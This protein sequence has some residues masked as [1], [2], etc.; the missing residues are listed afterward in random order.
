MNRQLKLGIFVFSGII[1]VAVSIIASGNFSFKRSYNVYA[2]FNDISGIT[3]KA[4]VKIAGVDIGV[5]KDISLEGSQANLK[6][7]I[8]KDI[9]LY[10]NS[11]VRIVSVG[12]IGTKYIEISPGDSSTEELKEGYYINAEQ[13]SD[14]ESMFKNI[15]TS[16]N[17]GMNSHQ[18]GDLMENLA[19][20]IYSLK[21]VMENLGHENKNISEII[22]NLNRFSRDVTTISSENKHDFRAVVLSI[23]DVSEKLDTL[24]NRISNGDG[25]VS[26]LINDGQM[27]RD[28][29]ETIVSAKETVK[30]LKDTVGRANKLQLSWNYTGRYDTKDKMFRNDIGIN[31][32]PNHNKFYYVG[33]SNVVDSNTAS[34]SEKGKINKL[35]ALLG[36]RSKKS[37]IYGGV[38][39]GKAGFGL[40]YSFF[41]PIWAE[42][43]RL[44]VYL[45]VYDLSREKHGPIVNVG[46]KVG[47]AQWLYAGIALEDSTYEPVFTPY[48]RVEIDDKDLAA[49]LGII[50]IAVVT[51]K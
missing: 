21:E 7:A 10:K 24:I 12:V 50:S 17:K 28:F 49:L 48:V 33:V 11:V 38:I 29:K 40:G 46:L 39:R 16:V 20:A 36:F 14:W 47:I 4:K 51:A 32:M 45:D 6:L 9:K 27:S 13:P 3:K 1:A 31:I 26:T 19:E 44:K 35:D 8:N 2:K 25:M 41:D 5:L 23:K 18:Y 30:G 15:S 37:E 42:F 22:N 43:R 34:N